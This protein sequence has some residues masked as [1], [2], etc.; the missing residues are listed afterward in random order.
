MSENNTPNRGFKYIAYYEPSHE[1]EQ[2]KT[3]EE[4]KKWLIDYDSQ[5]GIDEG[6]EFGK[7]FIAEITHVSS[8]EKTD[9][10]EN[11][12][13]CDPFSESDNCKCGAYGEEW[14]YCDDWSWI[15][16]VDYLPINTSPTE[17]QQ[18]PYGIKKAPEK[19][20]QVFED[21]CI[22]IKTD[23][24][25]DAFYDRLVHDGI[26]SEPQQVEEKLRADI[27]E[28]IKEMDKQ[29]KFWEVLMEE[30]QKIG[31]TVVG[32]KSI[33]F[34][35]KIKSII[36]KGT[37]QQVNQG[38]EWVSVEDR[39]PEDYNGKSDEYLV[40]NYGEIN[41]ATWHA[42]SYNDGVGDSHDGQ[43]FMVPNMDSD[44]GGMFVARGV[45]HWMP[46]PQP[47]TNTEE[48]W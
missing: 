9:F 45:T 47:P 44:Y 35:S 19:L 21:M 10:K 46:L 48:E 18:E 1:Y 33:E 36:Q 15:G 25:I 37:P 11:Y 3:I 5:D 32:E 40:V 41:L 12:C 7:S 4:A 23:F 17:S 28:A 8:V 2:F 20:K 13:T 22:E 27:R 39:L 29:V 34:L 6:T 24:S 38:S 42:H 31:W 14:P 16:N 43:Q 30:E 26:I